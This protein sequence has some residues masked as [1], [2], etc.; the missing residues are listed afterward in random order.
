MSICI[1][2]EKGIIGDEHSALPISDGKCSSEANYNAV[3]P[4][5]EYLAGKNKQNVLLLT[6][7]GTFRLVKPKGKYFVLE[8]LQKL[9]NGMIEFYPRHI[10]NNIIICNEEGLMK[11]MP[12]NRL[13]KLIL[14]IDLVGPVLIVSEKMR[15]TVCPK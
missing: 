4:Y 7:D 11:K 10:N 1:I 5:R 15:L 14:D 8:E 12:Y 2:I 6:T 9:V 3:I 13:D